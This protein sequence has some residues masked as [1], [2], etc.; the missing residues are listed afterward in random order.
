MT[1]RTLLNGILATSLGIACANTSAK[2]DFLGPTPYLS[3]ADSPFSGQPFSYF[4][5]ENFESG[6]LT[7]P[8]VTPSPGWVVLGP[9]PFTDSV[10]ADDGVIDGS[11]TKGHSF[12]SNGSSSSLT[13]TFNAAALGGHLPTVAGIVWTDVGNVASG[14]LGFGPVSFSATNELGNSLGSIGPFT[15]G[16]GNAMGG[17]AEDRFFGVRNPG[18]ISS[19]TITTANSTDWEVDHL[20]FGFAAAVSEP[21]SFVLTAIGLVGL[22]G[23]I[24]RETSRRRRAESLSAG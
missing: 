19:I 11:G 14:T 23:I 13:F 12:F 8:G 16:D 18:G 21:S 20:Q 24:M 9:G 5:L 1:R 4:F 6:A 17:T 10:D 22:Y 7:V 2:A 3:F 15:L